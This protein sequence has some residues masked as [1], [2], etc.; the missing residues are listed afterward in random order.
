MGT[1]NIAQFI[2]N[3]G[4]DDEDDVVTSTPDPEDNEIDNEGAGQVEDDLDE[5]GDP[6]ENDGD[7]DDSDAEDNQEEGQQPVNETPEDNQQEETTQPNILLRQDGTATDKAGNIVDPTSGKII[8]RSGSE[9]RLY[10][11]NVRLNSRLNEV[12]QKAEQLRTIAENS[13]NLYVALA[14]SGMTPDQIGG[15]IELLASYYKDPL[16]TTRKILAQTAAMGYNISQIVG[17]GVGDAIEMSAI[18]QMLDQRLGQS[19]P[20]RQDN[21]PVISQEEQ[22]RRTINNFVAS[23]PGSQVH[24]QTIGEM[25]ARSNQLGQPISATE[26]YERLREFCFQRGL[27]FGKPLPNKPPANQSNNRQQPRNQM[28]PR[29][30]SKPNPGRPI[31]DAGLANANDSWDNIV[32]STLKQR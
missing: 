16:E 23:H 29:R 26:A 7:D 3:D 8:A 9:R 22:N 6:I 20:Q 5:N 31:A 24:L 27:D 4:T 12:T 30:S 10:E 25:V 28:P 21:T 13:N 15:G 14:N 11:S 2:D 19:Q 1:M 18:K 32:R 17:E